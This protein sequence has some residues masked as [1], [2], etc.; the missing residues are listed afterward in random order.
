V[1]ADRRYHGALVIMSGSDTEVLAAARALALSLNLRIATVL[2]KPLR[3]AQLQEM[4]T[5]AAAT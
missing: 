2:E 4:F 1:L 3:L 5:A